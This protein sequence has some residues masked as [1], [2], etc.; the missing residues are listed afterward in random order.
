VA[1]DADRIGPG[2]ADPA[3]ALLKLL[4]EFLGLE[5]AIADDAFGVDD[6]RHVGD[7]RD[8]RPGRVRVQRR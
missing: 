4:G 5:A 1:V 6:Q 3:A 2:A 7:S 8:Q